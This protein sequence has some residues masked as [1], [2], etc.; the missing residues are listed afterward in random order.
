MAQNNDN[1]LEYLS[2]WPPPSFSDLP[3]N[4]EIVERSLESTDCSTSKMP[5]RSHEDNKTKPEGDIVIVTAETLLARWWRSRQRRQKKKRMDDNLMSLEN[6][7]SQ[8]TCPRARINAIKRHPSAKEF[9]LRVARNIETIPNNTPKQQYTLSTILF[10]LAFLEDD[11]YKQCKSDLLRDSRFQLDKCLSVSM[12]S[13]FT[14]LERLSNTNYLKQIY[15]LDEFQKEIQNFSIKLDMQLEVEN[16]SKACNF[17]AFELT[18]SRSFDNISSSTQKNPLQK[19]GRIHSK[20]LSIEQFI[21]EY[22]IKRK[23]LVITGVGEAEVVSQPWTLDHISKLSGRQRILLKKPNKESI[24]WAKLEPSVEMS[25]A[26]FISQV[27]SETSGMNY[28]FDW[29][30]PL[31]CPELNSEITIPKYFQ[32]DYLKKTSP[33]ALYRQSWPSLFISAKGSVSELHVDAFGSNFWMYLFQGRKRWTFFSPDFINALRPKYY[34]SLDPIFEIDPSLYE[35]FKDYSCEVILE[36]EELLF[37]PF[38]SPHRVENLEDSV[39]ISGNFVDQSNI[40]CV[41]EHLRKNALLDSRAGDLLRE[42]I[43]LKLISA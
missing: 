6:S 33:E 35:R 3:K 20:D 42:F 32:H 43:E 16:S 1:N 40:Q 9:L 21:N 19:V 39:A 27:K 13:S 17:P 41:V 12:P 30:L 29:S 22:S 5:S 23:P 4:G 37:V 7:I 2:V 25:V 34:E 38:G 14:S 15:E 8:S 11:E 24:K 28:L 36:P 31:H 10:N 18:N 26:E